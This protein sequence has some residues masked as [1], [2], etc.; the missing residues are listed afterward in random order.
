MW[1]RAPRQRRLLGAFVCAARDHAVGR[2]QLRK[3]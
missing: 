2:L 1:R 3:G